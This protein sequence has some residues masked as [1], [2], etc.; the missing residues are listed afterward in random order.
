MNIA[1]LLA[2]GIGSRMQS[3]VPKQYIKVNERMM[4]TYSLETLVN[5]SLI[6]R[7]VI[8]AEVEWRELI[9]AFSCSFHY[10]FQHLTVK[11]RDYWS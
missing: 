5:S 2:G 11:S 10:F 4:I 6:D 7:I 9:L 1:L 3:D 8:V